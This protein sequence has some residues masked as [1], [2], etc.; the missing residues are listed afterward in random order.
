MSRVSFV[1]KHLNKI[2]C[3][4]KSTEK[5]YAYALISEFHSPMLEEMKDYEVNITILHLLSDFRDDCEIIDCGRSCLG[6][7]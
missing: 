5:N 2:V 4:K 6:L 7:L 1:S 3:R